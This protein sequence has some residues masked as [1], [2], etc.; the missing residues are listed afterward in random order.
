VNAGGAPEIDYDH[1]KGCLTCVGVCPSHA[2]VTVPEN[3]AAEA[4]EAS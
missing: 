4:G 2:I 1:C 3:E